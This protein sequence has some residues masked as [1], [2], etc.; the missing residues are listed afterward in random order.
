MSLHAANP[1]TALNRTQILEPNYS[2]VN[3]VDGEKTL[4][5]AMK[6]AT[7][8]ALLRAASE[9]WTQR[10]PY[11]GHE[12]RIVY[13]TNRAVAAAAVVVGV[14]GVLAVLPLYVGWW[15]LGRAP[16]LNPLE[17]GIAMGAPLLLQRR[18]SGESR[19][20]GSEVDGG[21]SG[22]QQQSHQRR[23]NSN[24]SHAHIEN[25]VGALR[26]RYCATPA[27]DEEEEVSGGGRNKDRSA[28]EDPPHSVSDDAV[29]ASQTQQQQESKRQLKFTEG[30]I[31]MVRSGEKMCLRLVDEQQMLRRREKM[32]KPRKGERFL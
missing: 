5:G 12:S 16:S 15:E 18:A 7:G 4:E 28:V 13:R 29:F 9:S 26:V 24:A 17:M 25:Q 32:V 27:I 8:E 6:N 10:V 1:A 2:W 30:N 23:V 20:G 11:H 14:A 19:D 31:E 22:G 3:Y 21:R